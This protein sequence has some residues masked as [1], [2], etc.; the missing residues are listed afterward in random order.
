[1]RALFVLLLWWFSPVSLA[2][3]KETVCVRQQGLRGWAEPSTYDATI[4]RG[5][6]LNKVTRSQRYTPLAT[7][8]VIHYDQD[9]VHVLELELPR[10]MRMDQAAKDE[11]GRRWKVSTANT[12]V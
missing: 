10:L 7:Y 12:C 8:V 2:N 5:M 11:F 1:M 4:T 9:R 3:G 6:E